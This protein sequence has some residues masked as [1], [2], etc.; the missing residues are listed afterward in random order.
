MT[1]ASSMD[2]HDQ[3]IACGAKAECKRVNMELA[4]GL[5]GDVGVLLR[6][7]YSYKNYD[8]NGTYTTF[9]QW[10]QERHPHE[11]LLRGSRPQGSN[12]GWSVDAAFDDYHNRRYYVQFIESQCR[13]GNVLEGRSL[14]IRLRLTSPISIAALQAR[15]I[16][17]NKVS[18]P[19][20]FLMNADATAHVHHLGMAKYMDELEIFL[21]NAAGGHL[22]GFLDDKFCVFDRGKQYPEFQQFTED[23]LRKKYKRNDGTEIDQ[24][25]EEVLGELYHPMDPTNQQA[26]A[27]TGQLLREWA[28]GMLQGLRRHL[29][30]HK[31]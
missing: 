10:M 23:A 17:A 5:D 3:L 20:R 30:S 9:W 18:R 11:V 15:A 14:Y 28:G 29:N 21:A 16:I 13:D 25:H 31:N 4:A 12:G 6:L 8:A 19:F 24:Y 27:W 22:E 7:L 1:I 26:G 2:S